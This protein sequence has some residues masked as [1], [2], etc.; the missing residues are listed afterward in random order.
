MQR[1]ET[2]YG[3]T[4][5]TVA[6]YGFQEGAQQPWSEH[7]RALRKYNGQVPCFPLVDDDVMASLKAAP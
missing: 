4:L 7:Q 1:R 2:T 3:L 6:C 5:H